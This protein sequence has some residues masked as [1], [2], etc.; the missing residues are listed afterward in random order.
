MRFAS[1]KTNELRRR[2]D[3]GPTRREQETLILDSNCESKVSR[4]REIFGQTAASF[5]EIPMPSVEAGAAT[6]PIS[7]A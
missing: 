3:C 5:L 7:S 2:I 1:L 4:L 6:F